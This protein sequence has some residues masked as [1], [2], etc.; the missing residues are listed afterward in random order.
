MIQR[1]L[2]SIA[3][4]NNF[5]NMNASIVARMLQHLKANFDPDKPEEGY[6][7]QLSGRGGSSLSYS[8]YSYGFERVNRG[9]A[10][11]SHSHP[12][13][14]NFVL[15]TLTLWH[16]VS[17]RM[18]KLWMLSDLDLLSRRNSYRLC[19]TGQG[20]NRLQSC[21]NVGGWNNYT[22]LLL[23]PP[24]LFCARRCVWSQHAT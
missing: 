22:L 24:F 19:N 17:L 7:L 10:K 8:R 9:G 14:Y 20:L 18:Y 11:L 2:E 21:P 4:S 3:D 1:C 15:Q 5:L 23:L 13:Q 12:T 6:S 16:E